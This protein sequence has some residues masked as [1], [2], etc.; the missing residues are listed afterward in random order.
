[1]MVAMGKVEEVERLS[2]IALIKLGWFRAIRW[3]FCIEGHAC[4]PPLVLNYAQPRS[5][6]LRR[7]GG[8]LA[9][10]AA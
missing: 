2:H 8:M 7:F 5:E 6:L 4:S 9:D 3:L 1:M 10:G